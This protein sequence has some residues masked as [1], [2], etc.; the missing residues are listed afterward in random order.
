MWHASQGVGG[1]GVGAGAGEGSSSGGAPVVVQSP[2]HGLPVPA[3]TG[4]PKESFVASE[5]TIALAKRVKEVKVR[6]CTHC[7]VRWRG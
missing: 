1:A 7:R 4:L 3:H 2:L 6:G 5:R